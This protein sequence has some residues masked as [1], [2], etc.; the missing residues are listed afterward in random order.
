MALVTFLIEKRVK[1]KLR[2]LTSTTKILEIDSMYGESN[3]SEKHAKI[4]EVATN[5]LNAYTT[6]YKEISKDQEL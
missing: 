5:Y 1:N 4:I 2:D 3:D 6:M